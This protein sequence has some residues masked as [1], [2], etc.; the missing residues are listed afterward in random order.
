MPTVKVALLRALEQQFG[1]D[2]AARADT[3]RHRC[4]QIRE[5]LD[6]LCGSVEPLERGSSDEQIQDAAEQVSSASARI[7]ALLWEVAHEAGRLVAESV[8]REGVA[9][10]Y[11]PRAL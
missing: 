2:L 1:H 7:A 9:S 6:A 4:D 5:L 3:I 8:A 11:R 10:V